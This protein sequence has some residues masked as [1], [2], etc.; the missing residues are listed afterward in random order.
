MSG[1]VPGA[2]V[3]VKDHGRYNLWAPAPGAGWWAVPTAG[4]K[5][6]R[7]LPPRAADN[8]SWRMANPQ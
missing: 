1:H 2:G 3:D 4:G 5:A 8:G 7:I 6:V